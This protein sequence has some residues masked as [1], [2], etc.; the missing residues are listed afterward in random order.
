M[1]LGIAGQEHHNLYGFQKN[2]NG[3]IIMNS[4]AVNAKNPLSSNSK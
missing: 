1:L 4:N 2:N 3:K